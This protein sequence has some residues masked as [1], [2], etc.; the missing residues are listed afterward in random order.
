MT[1][2]ASWAWFSFAS[3]LECKSKVFGNPKKRA[4]WTAAVLLFF[5][6]VLV[7]S[8]F[9]KLTDS[10]THKHTNTQTHKN[11]H[12]LTKKSSQT[13]H[14]IHH[15]GRQIP[16]LLGVAPRI[17]GRALLEL[18]LLDG[19][20]GIDLLLE[21]PPPRR[22]TIP[23]KCTPTRWSRWMPRC[24]SHIRHAQCRHAHRHGGNPSAPRGRHSRSPQSRV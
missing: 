12:K 24:K 14:Y 6:K 11:P 18:L 21:L 13:R 3:F 2:V 8:F 5:F 20:A 4:T 17:V 19:G 23:T 9:C 22:L 15:I 16:C 10:Q 7:E 1:R